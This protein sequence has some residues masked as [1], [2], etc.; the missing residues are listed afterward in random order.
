M[1]GIAKQKKSVRT[2]F[3]KK[4][5]WSSIK[6]IGI[7]KKIKAWFQKKIFWSSIK[8]IGIAKKKSKHDF[9]KKYFEDLWKWDWMICNLLRRRVLGA[10]LANFQVFVCK[11]IF[12][13][14][15]K[16]W[17]MMLEEAK[18]FLS[19]SLWRRWLSWGQRW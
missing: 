9:R 8:M 7:A 4:L 6:M 12:L 13:F 16:S 18:S 15:L 17:W 5:F 11:V 2:W 3:K 1:I 19:H 14:D 10:S